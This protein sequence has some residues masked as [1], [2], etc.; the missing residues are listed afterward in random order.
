MPLYIIESEYPRSDIHLKDLDT[1][2]ILKASGGYL[3]IKALPYYPP[4]DC[5]QDGCDE[6]ADVAILLVDYDEDELPRIGIL[7]DKHKRELLVLAESDIPIY[8]CH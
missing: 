5:T 3:I 8:P 7:C 4:I 6:F 2:E 1:L